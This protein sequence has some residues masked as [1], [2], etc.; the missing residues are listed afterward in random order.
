MLKKMPIRLRL[1]V[2]TVAL[3]TVCCVGL[4]L[5]LNF[6]ADTMASRIDAALVLP[7]KEIGE[8]GRVD[9][10]PQSPSSSIII[11][12]PSDDSQKARMDFRFKSIIYMI[13]VIV[14]GGFLTYYISGKAL[15]PLDTLN[16]QVKNINVHNL[17]ETLSVPP[18]KDEIA[19][20]TITFNEMTDKLNSAF[21]MQ[22]RFSASAAHELRTPLAVLQ[23]KVDVFKK[24]KDHTNEEYNALISVIEKQTKRLRGLVGNLLDMTNMDD[25][26]EQSSIFIKDIFEDII[27]ELSHI[28]KDKNVTLSLDCDNSI[29]TG[30]TDLLYRAF[31]NLVENGIKYNIDGGTVGVIVNRLS[32]EEVSIKINDTGIGIAGNNKKNIFEPFYRVDKSRSRQMGGAG[33]GLSIV[34]SIIKKHHGTLTVTDNENGGTCFNVIL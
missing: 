20:L 26:G 16:G 17:S 4:T 27:S 12:V 32:K 11:P 24:K 31:Y 1:T 15:K 19:E 29:V 18:T 14:G 7:A 8:N 5:I 28:A 9:E 34:D 30:N 10:S 22:G 23:T 21:M 6:S 25:N 33:L 3:L 13:L 2:M